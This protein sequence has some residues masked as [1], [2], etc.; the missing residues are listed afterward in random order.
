MFA[1]ILVHKGR[2]NA[3]GKK[4][5]DE[6][7]HLSLFRWVLV[8]KTVTFSFFF[9]KK[10]KKEEEVILQS[11]RTYIHECTH[12][13]RDMQTHTYVCT[14]TC[15]NTYKWTHIY[16]HPCTHTHTRRHIGACSDSEEL[17]LPELPLHG[18]RL[19]Q[20]HQPSKS[21]GLVSFPKQRMHTCRST[22]LK[23]NFYKHSLLSKR[24]GSG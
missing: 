22:W 21:N 12:I 20:G 9:K 11:L 10:K 16:T 15:M 4:S 7:E 14:C 13:H 2:P 1:Q 3:S 24:Q 5:S 17:S 18:R 8:R 6:W 19:S 23:T